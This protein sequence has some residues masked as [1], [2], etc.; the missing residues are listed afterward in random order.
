MFGNPYVDGQTRRVCGRLAEYPPGPEC[1]GYSTDGPKS[2]PFLR[3]SCENRL[4]FFFLIFY[5]VCGDPKHVHKKRLRQ[6]SCMRLRR[7]KAR[8]DFLNRILLLT[9]VSPC[10][11]VTFNYPQCTRYSIEGSEQLKNDMAIKSTKGAVSKNLL[12]TWYISNWCYW[13]GK[14]IILFWCAR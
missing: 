2:S 12:I 4:S 11:S 9:V 13:S 8:W 5:W 10:N 6:L 1:G 7:V 14:V 3:G